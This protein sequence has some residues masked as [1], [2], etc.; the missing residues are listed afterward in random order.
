MIGQSADVFIRNWGFVA[1]RGVVAVVFGVLTI[2]RPGV[3]LAVL[4]LLFGGF[5]LGV[6]DFYPLPGMRSKVHPAAGGPPNKFTLDLFQTE[7]DFDRDF[8]YEHT[9]AGVEKTV[10]RGAYLGQG[11]NPGWQLQ[12]GIKP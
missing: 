12:D 11:K 7:T 5:V 4:I 8:N 9:S 3:T 6:M 10:F 1:L 2:L